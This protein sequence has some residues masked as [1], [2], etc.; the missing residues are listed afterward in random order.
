VP[1]SVLG[2]IGRTKVGALRTKIK[3]FDAEKDG[4]AK[5][6]ANRSAADSAA[7]QLL[8]R[9][10]RAVN[11]AI[12]CRCQEQRGIINEQDLLRTVIP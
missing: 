6:S 9:R 10:G 2:R 4:G 1:A 11:L 8:E 3:N 7:N 5:A 12:L